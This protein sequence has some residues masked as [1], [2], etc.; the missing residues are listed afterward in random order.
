ML[1]LFK[2]DRNNQYNNKETW[3]STIQFL[4]KE[5]KEKW[6]SHNRITKA[7]QSLAAKALVIIKT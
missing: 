3:L 5:I 4:R 1:I 7:A 6:N 2:A